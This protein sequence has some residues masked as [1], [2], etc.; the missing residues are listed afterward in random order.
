MSRY[1]IEVSYRGT[2]FSGFQVQD[3]AVTIQSELEKA[4]MILFK[5]TF[6]LTGSSRT[7]TGVHALQNYFHF[8]SAYINHRS[9]T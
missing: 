8:D 4:L 2:H 6:S 7:D 9:G 5:E 1:F 3:N